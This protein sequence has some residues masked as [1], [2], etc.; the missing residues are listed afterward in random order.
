MM[1]LGFNVLKLVEFRLK[2]NYFSVKLLGYVNGLKVSG[3]DLGVQLE[4]LFV[5]TLC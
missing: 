3:V 2:E 4:G 1:L 5:L